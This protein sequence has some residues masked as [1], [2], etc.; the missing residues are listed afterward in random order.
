MRTKHVF[1][2]VRPS[3]SVFESQNP[4]LNPVY[5]T[6]TYRYWARSFFSPH[7]LSLLQMLLY[8]SLLL[9]AIT[10]PVHRSLFLPLQSPIFSLF[11]TLGQTPTPATSTPRLDDQKVQFLTIADQ[12][13]KKFL[14]SQTFNCKFNHNE[15]QLKEY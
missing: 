5:K 2:Y 4:D 9:S 14:R 3:D 1:F 10:E 7:F 6:R 12:K 11:I 15:I 13:I 8:F